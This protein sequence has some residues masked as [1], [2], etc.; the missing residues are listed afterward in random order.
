MKTGT[1]SKLNETP[2]YNF[3]YSP[4]EEEHRFN[5]HFKDSWYGVR[6]IDLTGVNIYAFEKTVYVHMQNSET[7]MISI[8]DI[9]GQEINR[10]ALNNETLVKIPVITE[11]GYYLVKVESDS[12]IYTQKVFIK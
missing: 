9:M 3:T 2:V 8:F 12:C 1:I 4:L 10:V 6:I 11:S 5:L 7:G